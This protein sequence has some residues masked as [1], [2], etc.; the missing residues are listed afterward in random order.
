MSSLWADEQVY[1]PVDV[2]PY[3]PAA[4]FEGGK[5]NPRFRTKLEI[6]VELV[7]QAEENHIPFRAVVA[8]SFYGEDRGFR[9]GLDKLGVGYVLALKPSHG[10]RAPVTEIGSLYE[11]ARSQPWHSPQG[12]GN[13]QHVV[14]TFSDGHTESWWALEAVVE[15]AYGPSRSLRAVVATTDPQ[16]LPDSSTWYLITNLSAPNTE[17]AASSLHAPADVAE[18]VRLYGLRCWV[19]QSY[20]QVKHTLGWAQYQVRSD[21]AIRRHWILVW[22]AFTFCWWQHFDLASPNLLTDLALPTRTA[23]KK[24]VPA[25]SSFLAYPT[26]PSPGLARTLYFTQSLLGSLLGTAPSA[27]HSASPR[28]VI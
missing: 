27:T 25:T 1:Y 12:C 6:A 5:A 18:L 21:T 9:A 14:R 10:W 7:R 2:E 22:C 17:R 8:D 15:G 20:K 11:Y 24:T 3:T 4:W 23:P 28:L 16:Q 19:E 13:W 26:A